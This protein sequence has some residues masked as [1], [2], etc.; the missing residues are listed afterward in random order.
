[1]T[2]NIRDLIKRESAPAEHEAIRELWK[3]HSIAEDARDLPG[4]ISTLT[5]DC[6]YELVQTGDRWEGHAGA[7][8]FYL[9][10]LSAFPDIRFDLSDIVIGPQGVCEEADVTGT[11]EA[12]WL[13][14][15]PSGEQLA[16]KVAIFFPWD[17]AQRLFRGEKVYTAGL[18]L[19]D[20]R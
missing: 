12:P 4:L 11:H 9:E 7:A 19:T 15:P 8:R 16:W 14:F 20:G 1:M 10:L 5:T 6:V 17:P 13:G 3:R 18:P 2:G